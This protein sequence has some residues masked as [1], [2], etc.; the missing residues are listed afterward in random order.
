MPLSTIKPRCATV[1]SRSSS[2]SSENESAN[3]KILS[4]V[5]ITILTNASYATIAPILPLELSRYYY[6]NIFQGSNNDDENNEVYMSL[7]FLCFS[8]GSIVTP[9]LVSRHFETSCG[10][11]LRIMSIAMIGMAV[12]FYCLGSVFRVYTS[13]TMDDNDTDEEEVN[14]SS[15]VV[16]SNNLLISL[17]CTTQFCIGGF[18]SIVTTG[19]YSTATLIRTSN[20]DRIISYIE[21]AVGTGYILGPVIGS[22]LYDELGYEYVYRLVSMVMI[23]L[24]LVTMKFISP[25]FTEAR[26]VNVD[27]SCDFYS[28]D[29]ANIFEEEYEASQHFLLVAVESRLEKGRQSKENN[30][31]NNE[32][33]PLLTMSMDVESKVTTDAKPTI[34]HLLKHPRIL[35]SVLCITWSNVSWT[36]VEP[37]LATRLDT[38]F[39]LGKKEIGFIFSLSNFVY[40]P[41]AFLL[42]FAL[43]GSRKRRLVIFL[44]TAIT[45]LAVML[46]GSTSIHWL[47]IGIL[48]LGLLPTPVFVML[49]PSMQEDALAVYQDNVRY[50][51]M[52]NDLT[53]GMFNSFLSLGQVL[54]Y[55]LGPTLNAMVGFSTTTWAVASLIMMQ[56]ISYYYF[57]LI[58]NDNNVMKSV[59]GVV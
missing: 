40:I 49:L 20:P 12:L 45:P 46:V 54:G 25:L 58:S 5:F 9:P 59:R 39:H 28:E 13:W 52:A 8:L 26:K 47:I 38:Y 57:V 41:S 32:R 24:G 2:A 55:C 50:C 51:R 21:S 3:K 7:I 17:I 29:A 35:F 30:K 23:V 15:S 43:V 34:I 48:L 18:L 33:Q 31:H 22:Y 37:I 42:Q 53:A 16:V 6:N 19:Y 10:G 56:A 11:T 1:C 14:S 44:S 4:L 27:D 36:F